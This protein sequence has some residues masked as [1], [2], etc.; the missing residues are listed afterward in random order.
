MEGFDWEAGLTDKEEQVVYPA[1]PSLHHIVD[2]E[3]DRLKQL[4]ETDCNMVMTNVEGGEVENINDTTILK[5]EQKINVKKKEKQV[6]KIKEETPKQK[7]DMEK[8]R[9][10]ISLL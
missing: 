4:Y 9:F 8:T 5:D 3:F 7:E 10:S 1:Y 2:V 6:P